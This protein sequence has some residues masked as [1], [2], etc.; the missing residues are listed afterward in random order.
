[1]LV[2]QRGYLRA[3]RTRGLP[4][5]CGQC[6]GRTLPLRQDGRRQASPKHQCCTS[7]L[8]GCRARSQRL[9]SLRCL[10]DATAVVVRR[11]R[12][13][14]KRGGRRQVRRAAGRRRVPRVAT[15]EGGGGAGV[16]GAGAARRPR[17]RS[18]VP[19]GG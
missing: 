7:V 3:R 17:V 16:S 15:E 2:P 6:D 8:R 5:L 14:R 11:L 19:G 9:K 13:L 12:R 1:M 18:E 10:E 4:L